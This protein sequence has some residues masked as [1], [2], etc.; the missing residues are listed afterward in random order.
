MS[1][2]RR[3][4][5]TWDAPVAPPPELCGLEAVRAAMHGAIPPVAAL[6]GF[7]TSHAEPGCVRMAL[8]PAEYH[9][10]PIGSVHGG[11]IATVL[12]AALAAAIRT[13][14]PAGRACITVELKVCYVRA[15]IAA[16]GAVVAE[17]RV[18]NAGRQVALADGRLTDGTGRLI[19][20]ASS[21]CMVQEAAPA[22]AAAVTERRRVVE[23]DD[24]VAGARRIASQAGLDALRDPSTR[25]PVAALVGMAVDA[26]EPGTVRMS[27]P[28][29]EHLFSQFG[30]VHGGMIAVLL[31]SV[32]GCAV[33]STLPAGRGYTTLELQMRLLRPMTAASGVIT[34]TGQIV[35]GGRRMATAEA[36]AVDSAGRLC[37]TATTT[38]LVFDLRLPVSI[39]P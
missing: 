29:A 6:V 3:R 34:A 1:I 21:T 32:M 8:Q 15:L 4:V 37:A 18:V 26:V 9:Y 28:A 23:W 11:I 19:A 24:P 7:S 39:L 16:T 2:E 36:R 33:H 14:L 35:H 5:V 10:N 30:A 17:G 27:L 22:A 38:C 12:E 31:D 20:T 25:A 13:T